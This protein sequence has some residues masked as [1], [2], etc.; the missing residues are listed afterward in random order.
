M[1]DAEPCVPI[2][3]PQFFGL[4][5]DEVNRE[6]ADATTVAY[7]SACVFAK[8]IVEKRR[9]IKSCFERVIS[10]SP[11]PP[12]PAGGVESAQYAIEQEENRRVNG[13]STIYAQ[14]AP[15]E[16]QMLA[17]EIR[18]GVAET[19]AVIA[20]L[21]DANPVLREFLGQA[22]GEMES[23]IVRV[24]DGSVNAR[25]YYGRRLMQRQNEYAP[26]MDQVLVDHP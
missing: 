3:T 26:F 10:P 5:I 21:G 16:A 14:G 13:E 11:P 23:S 1:A 12:P 8:K 15:D 25:D 18:G 24:S 2:P 4:D 22:I 6:N 20:Q 9:R 7:R 19:R 17:D